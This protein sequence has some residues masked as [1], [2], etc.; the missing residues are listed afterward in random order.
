MLAAGSAVQ[1]ASGGLGRSSTYFTQRI[2]QS[3]LPHTATA[4]AGATAALLHGAAAPSEVSDLVPV[5]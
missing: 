2:C 1:V 4:E 5:R 3:V